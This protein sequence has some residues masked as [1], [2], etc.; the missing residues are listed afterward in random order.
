MVFIGFTY[1][2]SSLNH[3]IN[4]T[5]SGINSKCHLTAKIRN[6]FRI[7]GEL[8]LL[9]LLYSL[10]RWHAACLAAAINDMASRRWSTQL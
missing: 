8:G 1:S 2:S 3:F 9:Q 10:K 4:L 5:S 7:A 6:S